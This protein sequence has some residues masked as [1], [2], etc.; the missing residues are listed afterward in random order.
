[1]RDKMSDG[2]TD[3]YKKGP[4]S[5][6]EIIQKYDKLGELEKGSQI[7]RGS[8]PIKFRAMTKDWGVNNRMLY[9]DELELVFDE[10]GLRSLNSI[11]T[12]L[13]FMQ[14]TGIKDQNGKEVYER[15]LVKRIHKGGGQ[16]HMVFEVFWH[17]HSCGFR[18]KYKD[19]LY[20]LVGDDFKLLVVSNIYEKSEPLEV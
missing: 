12:E 13:I 5:R 7:V 6:E 8:R 1:V 4:N 19:V 18:M 9:G 11:G 16:G 17:S 15:D 10:H 14:Y 3:G 20:S 2:I